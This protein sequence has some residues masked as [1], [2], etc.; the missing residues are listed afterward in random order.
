MQKVHPKFE[1]DSKII[2][3]YII[4]GFPQPDSAKD[5]IS[6]ESYVSELGNILPIEPSEHFCQ[7]SYLCNN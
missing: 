5:G 4:Y 6:V 7:A 3:K 2:A 1:V